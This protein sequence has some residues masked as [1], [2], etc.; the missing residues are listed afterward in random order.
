MAE[1]AGNAALNILPGIQKLMKMES[2]RQKTIRGL[3]VGDTFSIVRSFSENDIEQF[4][5]ITRDDNPVHSDGRY[6]EAKNLN[7]QIC[8]GLLV[9]S[10]AT[11]I[12]G[13]IGWLASSLRFDFKKP[14]YVHD[15]VTCR[16]TMTSINESLRAE[17]TIEWQ[18]QHHEIVLT[19]HLKGI[20]PNPDERLI[21][22]SIML[23]EERPKGD[24]SSPSG[25]IPPKA[26]T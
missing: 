12:G 21:L 24:C 2:I 19:A 5:K 26:G 15:V 9:G 7:G 14:V 10:M 23:R 11:E 3:Q 20:L 8:H 18:N 1:D 6:I 16:L 13:Q 17:A 25:E 4:R 22:Q